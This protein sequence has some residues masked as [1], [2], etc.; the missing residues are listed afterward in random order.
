M[1]ELT[2]E[3]LKKVAAMI[4][5]KGITKPR[6]IIIPKNLEYDR[7]SIAKRRIWQRFGIWID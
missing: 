5:E 2:Q 7:I 3:E 6:S 4:K 1:K